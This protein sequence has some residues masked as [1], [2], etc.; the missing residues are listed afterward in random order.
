VA[1]PSGKFLVQLFVVP[2][3]IVGFLVLIWL[4][5]FKGPSYTREK[6]L[7]K[8]RS[9]DADVRWRAAYDLAQILPRDQKEANPQ[10]ALD[11]RFGL[12]LSELLQQSLK[13]EKE[14]L[15]RIG[16]RLREEAPR[17]Y[18]ELEE[19]QKYL[20]FLLNGLSDF[21]VPVAAP[22]LSSLAKQ[23]PA[24]P[25][26]GA[27]ERRRNAVLALAKLGNNLQAFYQ[28]PAE[29]RQAIL[30]ELEDEAKSSSERGQWARA[31]LAFLKDGTPLGVEA[32]L[33]DCAKADDPDLRKLSALALGFWRGGDSEETLLHLSYDD[34]HGGQPETVQRN[35]REVQYNAVL[36][37]ARRGSPKVEKRLGVLLDML[38]E[39]RLADD[40]TTQQEG[41]ALTNPSAVRETLLSTLEAVAELHRLRPEMNLSE[42]VPAL[43]KLA[44]S[45]D[46]S[47]KEKAAAARKQFSASV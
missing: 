18:H 7:D 8:L 37:L 25:P 14:M 33:A 12:D 47:V 34:G 15:D 39:A 27:I 16:S 22:L 35:Q 32:A 3:L 28:Q 38:D 24:N 26:E 41:R 20:G 44:A 40:F 4:L 45:T 23:A 31:T 43:D 13:E 11:P 30:A 1:P 2:F 6:F 19:Q 10:F 46:P 21:D 42:L 17:E 5:F 9:G 36:A 29:R